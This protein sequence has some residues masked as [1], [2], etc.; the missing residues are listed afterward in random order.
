MGALAGW[1]SWPLP[2][3]SLGGHWVSDGWT[4]RRAT[5]PGASFLPQEI[6][7]LFFF[8]IYC[9]LFEAFLPGRPFAVMLSQSCFLTCRK[10]AEDLFSS[11]SQLLLLLRGWDGHTCR[12]P[13][14][15]TNGSAW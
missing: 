7:L 14:G 5:Q 15:V 3:L 11:G 13:D 10:V 2:D 9:Q 12:A 6:I 1:A 4:R 8:S